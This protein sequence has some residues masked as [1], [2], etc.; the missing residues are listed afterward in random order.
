MESIQSTQRPTDAITG[1]TT[2]A[3]FEEMMLDRELEV[4]RGALRC[5]IANIAQLML[6]LDFKISECFLSM[7]APEGIGLMMLKN[8]AYENQPKITKR[9][10]FKITEF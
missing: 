5:Q 4:T 9:L 7:A 8:Y 2:A 1:S 3:Q 10:F 6:S